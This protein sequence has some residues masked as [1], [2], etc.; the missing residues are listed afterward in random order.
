MKKWIAIG[1]LLVMLPSAGAMAQVEVTLPQGYIQGE[2]L[3]VYSASH[4]SEEESTFFDRVDPAW[5]HPG[6]TEYENQSR[7]GRYDCFTFEDGAQL[8]IDTGYLR[9]G[10][11]DGEYF[12]IYGDDPGHPGGPF[13]R[14]AFACE[15]AGLAQEA[16][17]RAR[18]EKL[19]LPELQKEE[20]ACIT[21]EEADQAVRSILEK[22]NLEGYERIG[23]IDMTAERIRTMG[24]ASVESQR[25]M[26]NVYDRYYDFSLAQEQDEGYFL[27]YGQF[28]NG[29]RTANP[30]TDDFVDQTGI[31][32][33]ELRDSYA[34]GEV[35]SMPDRLLTAAEM[36]QVFAKDNPRREA[37]GFLNPEL[38]GMELKYGPMRAPD[39]QEG[40]VM[41]PVWYI[42]YDF[43]DGV[44]CDGW[45][46]YSAL[47]GKLIMDCYN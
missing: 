17:S 34:I 39:P 33:F 15:I 31:R 21:L 43:T 41:A 25:Q 6:E 46:W 30:D 40:M 7:R 29:L 9:Y 36:E 11:Y 45:A 22:L 44:R 19:P 16:V 38:T 18:W 20:M 37:D 32:L 8:L 47:D 24:T 42:T 1:L 3:P 5:F 14:P 10:E 27:W 28:Q 12:M 26:Y 23:A 4:R 13:A 2:A 35:A